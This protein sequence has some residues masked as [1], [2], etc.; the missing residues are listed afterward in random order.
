MRPRPGPR[1]L[2]RPPPPPP[3][4]PPPRPRNISFTS[5]IVQIVHII[6][7]YTYLPANRAVYHTA[8]LDR[9]RCVLAA[10]PSAR[11]IRTERR[12]VS[13]ATSCHSSGSLR[14]RC[15]APG[16]QRS[17]R[18]Q[19]IGTHRSALGLTSIPCRFR[20]QSAGPPRAAGSACS[21]A[22][23]AGLRRSTCASHPPRVRAPCE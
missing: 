10:V 20:L 22:W 3:L 11:S 16:P 14:H 5:S 12:V 21:A 9:S 19:D 17:L 8:P 4:P 15:L 7:V 18:N 23:R 2:P 6:H 13:P 1:P